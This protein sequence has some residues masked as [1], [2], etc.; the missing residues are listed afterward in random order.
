MICNI[1][2]RITQRQLAAA[3]DS[4]GFAGK[5]DFLY[6]PRARGGSS[7]SIGYSF[8]NMKCIE[9]VPVFVEAMTGYT[10]EG[11]FSKKKC[12]VKRARIQG[13]EG[14]ADQFPSNRLRRNR[15]NTPL[16]G[17]LGAE[18]EASRLPQGQEPP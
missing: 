8:I 6:A 10:F 16:T 7:P 14:N 17:K 15:W 2:C 1:P 5:Y 9:D 3:V 13:L 18:G 4:I 12:M 11:T